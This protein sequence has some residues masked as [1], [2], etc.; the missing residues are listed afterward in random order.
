MRTNALLLAA[1]LCVA[2]SASAQ[3]GGTVPDANALIERLVKGNE[4]FVGAEM[5]ACKA[6]DH[7]TREKLAK[8]QKPFAIV[9]SC[10][11]SRVPPEIVFDQGLGEIFVIRVAGNVPDPIV[12][13]S[14]EYAAEHLGSPLLVVLG[15]ER[16][17]A[18]TA[19]VDTPGEPEG[20]V[21]AI[22]K[23]IAP[24]V[25]QAKKDL[26]NAEKAELV[27]AAVTDNVANVAAAIPVQSKVLGKMVKDHK[28]TIVGATY[29]LDDGKVTW[30]KAPAK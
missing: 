9:L 25:K 17:G 28:I 6:S 4:R 3:D 19:A 16:C 30:L 20:N 13:G 22:I 29:D 14:I 21:G 11:D 7:W 10:S 15:H 26:P 23:A 12:L 2:S 1:V 5:A 8:G 24:A 27:Q 18:V